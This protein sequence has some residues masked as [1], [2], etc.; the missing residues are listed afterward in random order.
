MGYFIKYFIITINSEDNMSTKYWK[1][2]DFALGVFDGKIKEVI[3]DLSN[4]Y[5]GE[6]TEVIVDAE[7]AAPIILACALAELISILP[8]AST[9]KF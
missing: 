7:I 9:L 4:F 2:N 8:A 1:A 6:K 5:Y 3:A